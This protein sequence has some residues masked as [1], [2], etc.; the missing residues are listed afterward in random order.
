MLSQGG[1]S[2]LDW[3][4]GRRDTAVL[5]AG[6]AAAAAAGVLTAATEPW[7]G[8]VVMV[9][10]A[11]ALR[12]LTNARAALVAVV[13]VIYLLPFGVVPI[14][15]GGIRLTMLDYSL[16]AALL[17]WLLAGLT[18]H[19]RRITLTPAG[20]AILVF[21]ALALTTFLMALDATS[22]ESTRLFMKLINSVLFFFAVVNIVRTVAD[23]RLLT[24]AL[25]LGAGGAAGIALAFY[26][27]PVSIAGT[28]LGS[29]ARIGYPDYQVLR[30]IADTQI[31]RAT[32]TAVDP[33]V[34]GGMLLAAAPLAFT[35]AFS[36]Q[37]VLNRRLVW[38]LLALILG[39]LVL[40]YSRGSWFGALVGIVLVGAWQYRR[41]LAALALALVVLLATPQGALVVERFQNGLAFEDRASQMRLGEYKDALR[42]IERYPTLG[43]GFGRAP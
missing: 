37:P 24:A 14:P 33:N 11:L 40:S 2:L 8:F 35:Q 15:L 39:A 9:A 41:I 7:A 43:V 20:P 29:L 42:L 30:Y 31:L 3:R 19:D 36:P 32:G 21:V 12:I 16:T 5:L 18:R 26:V 10:A 22:A 23:L 27:I 6:G 25:L 4:W 17:V 28:L 34:L 38:V 13:A 1:G